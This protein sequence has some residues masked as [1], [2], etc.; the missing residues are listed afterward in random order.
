MLLRYI[1][2]V[3]ICVPVSA[4]SP[5]AYDTHVPLIGAAIREH[6]LIQNTDP[7]IAPVCSVCKRG[8]ACDRSKLLAL[9]SLPVMATSIRAKNLSRRGFFRASTAA[10]VAFAA[11]PSMSFSADKLVN[12]DNAEIANIVRRD[13]VDGQFLT[14]GRLTRAIYDEGATFTDE[15]DTYTLDKVSKYF[16]INCWPS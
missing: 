2:P 16:P 10:L 14:N 7:N 3:L 11:A 13:L 15:I 12:L 6:R 1:L 5:N 8:C 9:I 4:F